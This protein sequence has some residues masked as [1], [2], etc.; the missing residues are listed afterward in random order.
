[1]SA[2]DARQARSLLKDVQFYQVDSGHGF[3]F[4]RPDE[5]ND[6]MLDLERRLKK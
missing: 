5:F 6:I 1:M 2:N 3:H 4:E